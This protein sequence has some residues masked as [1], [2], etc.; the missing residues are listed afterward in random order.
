VIHFWTDITVS[1]DLGS[2][3]AAAVR[4]QYR[5]TFPHFQVCPQLNPHPDCVRLFLSKVSTR[6]REERVL[7]HHYSDRNSDLSGFARLLSEP[8]SVRCSAF[9]FEC[10]NCGALL[11][12]FENLPKETDTFAFFACQES[13]RL[14]RLTGLPNDLFSSCLISP[15]RTALLWHSRHYYAFKN[16][17]LRPLVPF[18]V[19]DV[20][21][22]NILSEIYQDIQAMLRHTVEAIAF[23]KMEPA[24]FLRLFRTDPELERL[25]VYFVFA[26][27]VMDFFSITP[28]SYPSIPCI[29]NHPLWKAFDLRMD[30]EL[31]R[32]KHP[33]PAIFGSFRSYLD[34]V[35]ISLQ[36][37]V[38]VH[39]PEPAFLPQISYVPSI[40]ARASQ[41]GLSALASYLDR[42]AESVRCAIHFPILSHLFRA[43]RSPLVLF[44]LC[45]FVAYHPRYAEFGADYFA[46]LARDLIT[47][48]ASK[49]HLILV[50]L[51][52]R[53]SPAAVRSF[54]RHGGIPAIPHCLRSADPEIREWGLLALALVCQEINE[55]ALLDRLF[56]DVMALIESAS[57]EEC[58]AVVFCLTRLIPVAQDRLRIL[59]CILAQSDQICYLV[60]CQVLSAISVFYEPS[61][62]TFFFPANQI[63][64]DARDTLIRY[65]MDSHATVAKAAT[66]LIESLT[67]QQNVVHRSNVLDSF[68][69]LVL[70][71]IRH[72]LEAPGG[73]LVRPQQ[74]SL[75]VLP[76]VRLAHENPKIRFTLRETYAH[77][78][79]ITSNLEFSAPD[80]V[81]F[82][83]T[84]DGI[85][86]K[87]WTPAK[88]EV[89]RT[90]LESPVTCIRYIDN[91][92]F[93]LVFA[94]NRRGHCLTMSFA[95]EQLTIING[96]RFPTRA[97]D[98]TDTRYCFEVDPVY[99][100]LI[101]HEPAIS[102]ALLV[103]DLRMERIRPSLV[104]PGKRVCAAHGIAAGTSMI[105]V[106]TSRSFEIV[107]LR[108]KDSI[109]S[110]SLA[111]DALD[112]R[113]VDATGPSFLVCS[114]SGFVQAI[115]LRHIDRALKSMQIRASR[116]IDALSFEML[117]N[118]SKCCIGHRDG[119]AILDVVNGKQKV[120]GGTR[121][122]FGAGSEM[123]DVEHLLFDPTEHYGMMV[124]HGENYLSLLTEG[125]R[126]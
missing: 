88:C 99:G 92:S 40:L 46:S 44:C 89:T 39:G 85:V 11:S 101:A 1:G 124:H 22:T 78:L 23:Q 87:P 17:P 113:V 82:G 120:V 15:A 8:A 115:D 69:A 93:P 61:S 84:S 49:L 86:L 94:S 6:A 96:M 12:S 2:T 25:V 53:A 35:V 51:F 76:P 75:M 123:S 3:V 16:G 52:L 126:P 38:G 117:P 97:F 20:E 98:A 122:L 24:L 13:E 42:S 27:R 33:Q 71:P 34:E 125:R 67:L 43:P 62:R 4:V 79:P 47:S 66:T 31:F 65:S 18:F 10:D 14:P 59:Q 81:L 103:Y 111:A 80:Y 37:A 104:F 64:T 50:V 118:S 107:D 30:A 114:K 36:T 32:L 119:L 109:A 105:G 58:V 41:D 7:I 90:G 121:G 56:S 91:H 110:F 9:I 112:F 29:L 55:P 106:C 70:G 72:I 73:P 63:E 100:R 77:P 83:D 28:V 68:V 116:P 102:E 48:D 21:D 26:C 19:D 108:M 95:D 57:S 60:R 74:I 45:K 54:L 5:E